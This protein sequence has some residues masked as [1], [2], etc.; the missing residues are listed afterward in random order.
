MST[1]PWP[2]RVVCGINAFER[3]FPRLAFLWPGVM[4]TI[5]MQLLDE[6]S[7]CSV[8]LTPRK[9][10]AQ[11]EHFTWRHTIEMRHI[12]FNFLRSYLHGVWAKHQLPESIPA[13]VDCPGIRQ[14]VEITRQRIKRSRHADG[15]R[16]R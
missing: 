11:P 6:T 4:P 2:K 3:I 7:S 10:S 15:H 12:D 8:Q 16:K 1:R 5:G 13:I 9:L 14:V